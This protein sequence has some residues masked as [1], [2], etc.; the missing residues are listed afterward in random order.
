MTC[1]KAKARDKGKSYTVKSI[2]DGTDRV[3]DRMQ[4]EQEN[5]DKYRYLTE[6]LRKHQIKLASKEAIADILNNYSRKD[7][8][9]QFAIGTISVDQAPF[10]NI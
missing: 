8:E 10:E 9:R 3:I 7:Q 6:F 1:H 5:K 2:N 4:E